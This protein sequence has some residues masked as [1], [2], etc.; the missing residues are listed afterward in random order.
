MI[1][2]VPIVLSCSGHVEVEA[3]NPERAR[4]LVTLHMRKHKNMYKALLEGG[5][6]SIKVGQNVEEV[7]KEQSGQPSESP[8][9]Q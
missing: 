9:P 2:R 6:G 3:P 1:W 5:V 4:Y 7:C 8:S